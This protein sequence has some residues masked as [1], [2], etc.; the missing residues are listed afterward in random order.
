VPVK[1]SNDKIRN[2]TRDLPACS[3]MLIIHSI[4]NMHAPLLCVMDASLFLTNDMI[5]AYKI[6]SCTQLQVYSVLYIYIICMFIVVNLYISF[7]S[8]LRI[9]I[10]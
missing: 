3:T 5:S 8:A 9:K 6:Y 4:L 7:T 2:R 1:N 10:S